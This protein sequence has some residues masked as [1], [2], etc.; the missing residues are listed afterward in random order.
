[1]DKFTLIMKNLILLVLL[2]AGIKSYSQ[3]VTYYTDSLVYSI[4]TT[5]IAGDDTIISGYVRHN[6]HYINPDSIYEDQFVI[7]DS[8]GNL[9]VPIQALMDKGY[10]S[11]GT[12]KRLKL[13]S[14]QIL[15]TPLQLRDSLIF[16]DLQ[17]I[18]GNTN[19]I[20]L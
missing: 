13:D 14:T 12:V 1:M 10:S 18:Y 4:D 7:I 17:L 11:N 15:W 2:F 5:I 8:L 16:P 19:V 6:Y 3:T 20:K 9:L